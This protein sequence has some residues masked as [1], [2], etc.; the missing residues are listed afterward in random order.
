MDVLIVGGSGLVGQNLVEAFRRRSHAVVG[1]YRTSPTP[2]TTAELDKTDAAAVASVVRDHDPDVVVD[3]AAFHEVDACETNRDRAFTVNAVG[4][5][6]AAVAATDVDAQ[7]VYLST[8]YVFPGEPAEA[9]Y[10][11]SDPIAPLNYYGKTKFAGEQA[12]AV[13]DEWTVLRPSVI[14]GL[15]RANFVTWALSELR[16]NNE[17]SIVD[18]QISRPTYAADLARA[19][20]DLTE[21]SRTGLYH[22]TGPDSRSRY[23][24]TRELAAAFDLDRDLIEPITTEEFGQEAPRPTDS[25]LDSTRLYETLGWE[26]SAPAEAFAELATTGE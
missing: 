1:T 25:S 3:T 8:D 12:A 18:D 24:F 21:S 2:E 9:P 4:T 19:C 15:D 10:T 26:F 11:E 16:A 22:A 6:N 5:R 7:F 13:A 14:Y 23:E 20:V 17:I